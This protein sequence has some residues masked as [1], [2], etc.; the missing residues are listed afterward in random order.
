MSMGCRQLACALL[1]ACLAPAWPAVAD[2]VWIQSGSGNPIALPN[3]K[4][5]GIDAD[6]LTFT[7]SSGNQTSKPL[8]SI[9]QIKL[10]DEPAFSAAEAAFVSKDYA[11]ASDQYHKAIESTTKQWVKDR[12]SVRLL[13][14]ANKSGSFPAAVEG[15]LQ[16]LPQ[17]LALASQ[18]KPVIPK[19][20]PDLLDP[21]IA[22]VKSASEDPKL[23]AEQKQVLLG[24]LAELYNA[25]G[26]TGQANTAIGQ[27]NK[28]APSGAPNAEAR[29]LAADSKLTQARQAFAQKQ[30]GQVAQILNSGATLFDP[31]QQGDALYLL[32]QANAAGANPNDP[33]QLKDAAIA[34]MRVA[35]VCKSMQ[36]QPHVADSLLQVAAIEEKLK[37]TKEALA[38]YNQVAAE[39]KGSLAAAKAQAAVERLTPKG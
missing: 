10:D 8:K 15:F 12:S 31:A 14:A 29:Q 18:N 13:D 11:T 33:N 32:A 1:L 23:S 6:A 39:F 5:T 27:L 21:V 36:G 25:K 17:N 9:P 20:R 19:D 35:A 26:D 7:T 2:T 16:L 34:Y 4:V 22:R 3:V 24:Y 28:M 30:Y 37:S 38:V